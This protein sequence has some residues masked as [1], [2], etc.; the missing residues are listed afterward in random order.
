MDDGVR[1]GGRLRCGT[2]W[3]SLGA[4]DEGVGEI[5]RDSEVGQLDDMMEECCGLF[6]S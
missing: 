4:R 5:G 1:N 3:I 6:S 2:Y